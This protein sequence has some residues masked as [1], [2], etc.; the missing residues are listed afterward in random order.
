MSCPSIEGTELQTVLIAVSE[1]DKQLDLI[2]T[3][4]LKLNLGGAK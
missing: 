1:S 4:Q 2:Q 3:G